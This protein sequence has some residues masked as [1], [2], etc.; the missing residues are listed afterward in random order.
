[1]CLRTFSPLQLQ[2][3]MQ[4]K[5]NLS[6]GK[7]NAKSVIAIIYGDFN[8]FRQRK[9]KANLNPITGLWSEI[10]N[11]RNENSHSIFKECDLKKQSQF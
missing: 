3:I 6:E 11:K 10:R 2:S 7:I 4:N 5:A 8:G 9:N 1:M